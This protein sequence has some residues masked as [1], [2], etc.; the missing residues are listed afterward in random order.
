MKLTILV[1]LACISC[2]KGT[3]VTNQQQAVSLIQLR[4]KIIDHG[5]LSFIISQNDKI[6][7]IVYS[8][9]INKKENKAYV[10]LNKKSVLSNEDLKSFNNHKTSLEWA[11]AQKDSYREKYFKV[12][13]DNFLDMSNEEKILLLDSLTST[14]K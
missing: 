2:S 4:C 9:S 8:Y 14:N 13:H 6:S 10:S 7:H 3:L 12:F 1:F 11:K 5:Y